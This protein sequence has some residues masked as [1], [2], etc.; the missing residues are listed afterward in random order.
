M[1]ILCIINVSCEMYT[2]FKRLCIKY[3]RYP[4]SKEC[5][6][7]Y[8]E[9]DDISVTQLLCYVN[10]YFYLLHTCTLR[11]QAYIHVWPESVISCTWQRHSTARHPQR[12][13]LNIFQCV[14]CPQNQFSINNTGVYICKYIIQISTSECL[15][16][17]ITG[18]SQ[19]SI[20][21]K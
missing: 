14:L 3:C 8:S 2:S 7:V 11:M 17:L 12:V 21:M 13:I 5:L 10:P 16:A 18:E 15:H 19:P 20:S 6:N 4:T 1:W 9:S